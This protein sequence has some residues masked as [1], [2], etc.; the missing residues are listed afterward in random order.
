MPHKA[1]LYA[2][3]IDIVKDGR[4]HMTKP[5]KRELIYLYIEAEYKKHGYSPSINE[6]TE[7]LGL[8]AKSNV[9]RQLQQLVAEGRLLNLG[10]RYVPSRLHESGLADVALVPLLGTVAAGSPILAVE[11]LEGYVAYL[12]RFGDSKE[13]FALKIRGDSMIEAGIFNGDIVIVEKTHEVSNG[14]I[15]VALIDDEATV[16]TFYREGGHI[17]LQPE[18]SELEPIIVSDVVV[19]GR[20][21]ASMRYHKNR[22]F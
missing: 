16:K 22:Q 4:I 18:N 17:R 20:V 15:A 11:N 21:L 7:H 6:V 1:E 8:S 14:E 19:L 5:D 10:G 12:P 2:A 9:H 3:A 13:L